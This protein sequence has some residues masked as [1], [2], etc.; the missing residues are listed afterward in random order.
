MVLG[1]RVDD[2]VE[3]VMEIMGGA[4]Q[5]GFYSYGEIS[6]HLEL[7]NCQLHNQTMTITLISE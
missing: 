1:Q 6:P 3:S 2:E 7:G 5:I 4:K